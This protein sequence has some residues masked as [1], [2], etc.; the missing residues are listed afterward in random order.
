MAGWSIWGDWNPGE[1]LYG[2][3]NGPVDDSSSV[4]VFG[5]RSRPED[6]L[7]DVVI[8]WLR[9]IPRDGVEVESTS[10]TE[11]DRE[12][13]YGAWAARARGL[14]SSAEN[15]VSDRR[16]RWRVAFVCSPSSSS[17][18]GFG[19]STVSFSKGAS[20]AQRSGNLRVSSRPA[21]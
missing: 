19:S 17:R 8:E 6:A 1:L 10:E 4:S 7:S 3:P 21:R 2:E 13:G 5:R 12:S 20:A 11:L 14:A 16:E 18:A 15:E 9:D